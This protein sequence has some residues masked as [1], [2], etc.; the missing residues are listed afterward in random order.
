MSFKFFFLTLGGYWIIGKSDYENEVRNSQWSEYLGGPGKN[1]YSSLDQI[2]TDNVNELEAAWE[3]NTGDPGQMQFNPIIIG[4]VLYGVTA[5]NDVFALDASSGEELWKYTA[6]KEK[7]FLTN[8]GVT[9]WEKGSDK[10]ILFTYK[11]WLIALDANTGQPIKSFG[12]D[13]RVSLKSGLGEGIDNKYLMSRTPGTIYEDLIIMPLVMIEG[14]GAAPGY[15]QAFD[16]Q[17]GELVWVFHTIPRPGEFGYNTWPK[18]VHEDGIIGGAN[19]WAGMAIDHG[20]GILYAPTG[21]AAPDF[22]GG[23]RKGRNLFANSLLALDANTGER[24]W[25]YQFVRHDLWDR[26]PPAPPILTTISREGKEIDVVAQVTKSGHVFVFNRE[27]GASIFPIEEV[28]VPA[29]VLS[30]EDAW[31]TQPLPVLPAPFSRQTLTED[32]LNMYS[33]D[34]DSLLQAFHNYK[35]GRFVPFSETP[36][37]IFPGLNGGAEWGGAAVDQSG[38]MYVNSN[39]IPWVESLVPTS[40]KKNSFSP[41][42]NIYRNNCGSCHGMDR[43]GN[44]GSGYPSLVDIEQRLNQDEVSKIIS[45]G[46]GMMPGFTQLTSI[47]KEELINFLFDKEE[48]ETSINTNSKIDAS[49]ESEMVPWKIDRH[50]KFLD[51]EGVPGISPPWG[52][53]TAINLNTGKHQWRIP[54]GNSKKYNGKNSSPTGTENYGGPVVTAG[55][56]L[57]IAATKDAKIRAFN[58][59]TGKLLWDFKLP[60]A[61]FATP[62]T[63]EVNGKQYIV[64]AAGGTKLGLDKGDSI[65]AFALPDS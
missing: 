32:D 17:T 28:E 33:P 18:N 61:G 8:R 24:I 16:V 46:Q 63:Y 53:L 31:P 26:D 15:I 23:N 55:G 48:K 22:F 34:Y 7:N 50:R 27:T 9:Y 47:E 36:T 62:S 43:T 11:E 35:K 41:G 45:N 2:D 25:H 54:L 44:P 64:I 60:A 3:Y 1:Q 58:K 40:L 19:N 4:E 52:T 42:E 5:T 13:G 56:L 29:S 14:A 57:F 20:R 10:R 65:I 30:E 39:E 12:N 59:E 51:S 37:I 21:S 49:D 38:I 6:D